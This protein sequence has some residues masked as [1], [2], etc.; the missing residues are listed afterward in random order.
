MAR[1]NNIDITRGVAILLMAFFQVLDFFWREDVYTAKPFA[2]SFMS[3]PPHFAVLALFLASAGAGMFLS[4][5]K[6]IKKNNP[7]QIFA[8]IIQRYGFFIVASAVFTT[9]MWNFCTFYTWG[10]A[11]QGIGITAIVAFFILIF[12][13]SS[14][15]LILLSAFLV[16]LQPIIKPLIFSLT[17]SFPYCSESFGVVFV[18]GLILNALLRG[19]FSPLNL[20]PLFLTGVI[21]VKSFNS[22]ESKEKYNRIVFLTA[23]AL[24]LNAL[25]LHF[26]GFVINFYDRTFNSI[27]IEVGIVM[28]IFSGYSLLNNKRIKN[29]IDRILLPYGLNPLTAY[30]AHFLLVLKPLQLLN[31]DNS[32]SLPF[33]LCASIIFMTA[34]NLVLSKWK[35]I[36]YSS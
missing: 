23:V 27:M 12:N 16:F 17:S 7:K 6:R 26:A 10:E 4:F 5:S 35:K 25:I 36:H 22:A 31:L 2:F 24:I 34:L 11:I 1:L 20:L 18:I 30:L 8:H 21:L 3:A 9:F 15:V 28:F 32:L 14:S 19:F 29:V 33:S 13:P